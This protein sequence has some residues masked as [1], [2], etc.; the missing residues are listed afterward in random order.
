MESKNSTPDLVPQ[1]EHNNDF[2]ATLGIKHY[3]H[4]LSSIT[5]IVLSFVIAFFGGLF[6]VFNLLDLINSYRSISGIDYASFV[7]II[8]V[9]T[10]LL[11]IA[12]L[13]LGIVNGLLSLRLRNKVSADES[14]SELLKTAI[15]SERIS[16]ALFGVSFFLFFMLIAAR[17]VARV[18]GST[19]L[20][21]HIPGFL[22]IFLAVL[23][24]ILTISEY[25]IAKLKLEANIKGKDYYLAR[26][27]EVIGKLEFTYISLGSGLAKL[28][29]GLFNFVMLFVKAFFSIFVSIYKIA[30]QAYKK[31]VAFFVA[32]YKTFVNH[33]WR[34][35]ISYLFIGSGHA[36]MKRPF[37]AVLYLAIQIFYTVFMFLPRGGFYYLSKFDNLGD[38]AGYWD[39]VCQRPLPIEQC[40]EDFLAKTQFHPQDNSMLIVL[41]SVAT[42]LLTL[43]IIVIY[44]TSIKSVA[45]ADEKY[46]DAKKVYEEELRIYKETEVNADNRVTSILDEQ[47]LVAIKPIFKNPLP[48][49]VDELKELLNGRFHFTTL[50]IPTLSITLFT[51]LPLVFMI[52]LAFTNFNAENGPPNTLFTWVG[53]QTF[54][55][56]FTSVGGSSFSKAFADILQWTF[57]WAF[58]ATFS[59]YI[60]GLILAMI[61]NRKGI[62]LKKIWRTIF[63]ITIAVPQ[64]V[65]LLLMS[66]LLNKYGPLNETLLQ[67]G[68]ISNYI[69][70]LT[71]PV[72]AKISVIL[73]NI[74]VGVPYT[75]LITSGILMNIP[76]DLYESARIDGAGT[77]TQFTKI[78]L[79][80][81]LFVTGPYLIT[82]FIGNINNFNVIFF[83][84]GG[85]PS[86][87]IPGVQYGKTDI[88][89]TW[90][91]DL[92]VNGAQQQYAIG[93][94]LGI[95]IFLIS[96]FITLALYSK[97]SA[98]TQEGDFA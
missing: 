87:N 72:N 63:V 12:V 49:F 26:P 76:S 23:L 75:M 10:A 27:V 74:W 80:Y 2:V 85:D 19:M 16:L 84:T 62:K 33:S 46:T 8:K 94:A 24:S 9:I 34:T 98:A 35:K 68:W 81:M 96:V 61:I 7:L 90:L 13:A 51:I 73:V 20:L 47:A 50:T 43:G 55:Q 44:W 41:F 86:A 39:Y 57:I 58:F 65:T 71:D 89:V 32:F 91:Y 25:F 21:A 17:I 95:F 11:T 66:R 18:I 31:A 53:L 28:G 64:F 37:K 40:P 79:P 52:L 59:N 42:I 30:I 1:L 82:Q 78:T 54:S 5:S 3:R 38:S 70:F 69:D 60:F 45:K 77:F 88:L 36:F 83:L 48:T 97:T 4:V 22:V 67:L 14:Q 15:L 93:S 29:I 56:L 92:T 6:F